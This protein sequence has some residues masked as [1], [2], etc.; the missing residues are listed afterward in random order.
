MTESFERGSTVHVEPRNDLVGHDT[1]TD[2][3]TCVCGPSHEPV[4]DQD[5]GAVS[6]YVITHQALDGRQ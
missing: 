5:T 3:A 4:F 2:E 6:G 1:S